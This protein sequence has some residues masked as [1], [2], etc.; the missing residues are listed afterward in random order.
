MGRG[1]NRLATGADEAVF[2]SGIRNG[3]IAAANWST[4]NGGA[5]LEMTLTGRGVDLPVWD[6]SNPSSVEAWMQA[7]QEFAAGARGNVRVLQSDSV[8]LQSVWAEVEFP[9]LRANPSVNSIRA[10][11]PEAG[12]EVLLWKR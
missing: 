7:S 11:N 10:V 4:Q 12:A 9:A 8:R 6:A 2:W 3:D 5:T 1:A